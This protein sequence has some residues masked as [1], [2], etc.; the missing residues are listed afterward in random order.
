MR[1]PEPGKVK[2]RIAKTMGNET[3]LNIYKALLRHTHKI[4]Q[5][6]AAQKFVFYAGG[7]S[8]NDIW[9]AS[10]FS[11]HKQAEADLGGKMIAAFRDVFEKGF[12]KVLIVGSDCYEL[13]TEIIEKAFLMLDTTDLVFGPA[14]DGGYYLAGQKKLHESVFNLQEWST[15]TVLEESLQKAAAAGLT[16]SLLPT[17]NDVDEEKDVNFPY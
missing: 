16:T 1:N 9:D 11:K 2:T 10:G 6:V 15:A 13:T 14:V 4:V 17:L 7:I 3:A 8:E 5:P 12:E